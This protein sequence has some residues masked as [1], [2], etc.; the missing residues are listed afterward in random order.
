MFNALPK[1][2]ALFAV[3]KQQTLLAVATAQRK[4]ARTAFSPM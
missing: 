1:W 4:V 3:M 2:S